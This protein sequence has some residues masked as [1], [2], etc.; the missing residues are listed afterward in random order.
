MSQ[1][2]FYYQVKFHFLARN[3]DNNNL[4][5]QDWKKDFIDSN[6]LK[7]RQEAFIEFEEYLNFLKHSNKLKIDS[8]GNLRIISPP[9]IPSEPAF[10]E[11]DDY[12]T[13][14]LKATKYHEFREDLDVLIV[15]TDENLMDELGYGDSVLPIHTVSSQSVDSQNLIGNLELV[16]LELYRR[17]GIDV[18]GHIE[19]VQHYGEDY[20]ESGEDEEAANWTILPTPFVWQTKEQYLK[21][22]GEEEDNSSEPDHLSWEK[23]IAGGESNSLELKSSLA[24]NFSGT[25]PNW[26]PMYKNAQTICGLLN[27]NGGFLVIG[28]ADDG[29]PQG[30]EEDRKLLGNKD[31]IRL[32]IDDLMS[33]Y[34]NNTIAPLIDVTFETVSEKEILVITVKPSDIPIFLRKYN[35]RT[36]LTSK[37]F[38]VRRSA[39]TTELKDVEDIVTYILNHWYHS[40]R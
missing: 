29:T 33:T 12:H 2:S 22:I 4:V 31:K 1:Y 24:F 13:M 9:N 10:K 27:S 19:H 37:H 17:S 5:F 38:L 6:P 30:L 32:K 23:I 26:K 16:E 34:F 25:L 40:R 20:E 3:D 35:S 15:I 7:A 36:A 8:T 11:E 39:S 21:I 28:V 14:A 18:E